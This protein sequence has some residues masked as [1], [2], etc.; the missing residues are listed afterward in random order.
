[1]NDPHIGHDCS[2][3]LGQTAALTVDDASYDFGEGATVLSCV[4]GSWAIEDAS[5]EIVAWSASVEV[6]VTQLAGA[7]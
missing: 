7:A 2:A 5:G 4:C 6:A 1:M 3:P